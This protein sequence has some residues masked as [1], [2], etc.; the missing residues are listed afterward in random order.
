MLFARWQMMDWVLDMTHGDSCPWLSVR[1]ITPRAP[2]V[3][4]TWPPVACVMSLNPLRVSMMLCA[5]CCYLK[6][7]PS[8]S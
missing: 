2:L 7:A 5:R 1:Q 8:C 4:G 3:D 6:V